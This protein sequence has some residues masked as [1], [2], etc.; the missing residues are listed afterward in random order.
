MEAAARME[1]WSAHMVFPH[2]S[3]RARPAM[4]LTV[5]NTR[6][7][8]PMV[9]LFAQLDDGTFAAKRMTETDVPYTLQWPNALD[10]VAVYIDPEPEQLQAILEA[11]KDGRLDYQRLQDY[12][13]AD[14]GTSVFEV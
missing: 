14:S 9:T 7:D 1:R 2:V 5:S 13:A 4:P 8:N 6:R 12:G 11:L 10:Q 3:I